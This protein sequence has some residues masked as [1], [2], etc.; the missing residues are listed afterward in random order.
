MFETLF[1]YPR[2]LRPHREGPL[3]EER[4]AYRAPRHR[5]ELIGVDRSGMQLS[6]GVKG[7]TGRV[8][9]ISIIYTFGQAI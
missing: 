8:G 2:V 7:M 4:A 9:S 3:A 1:T 5:R 6:A